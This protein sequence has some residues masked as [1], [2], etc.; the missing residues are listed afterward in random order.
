MR[1]DVL[2][3]ERLRL[4]PWTA[5]HG[6]L[7]ARLA[8]MPEVMRF[9]GK[10]VTLSA[11]EAGELAT[12]FHA[13]WRSH[14]F[15]WRGAVERDGGRLVGLVAL[16]LAHDVPGLA[17]GDHEIGWWFDPATWGRG[18]ATEGARAIVDE[19]WALGA[20][21]V[22]AR[23]QPGNVASERVA[24]KLGLTFEADTTGRYGEPVR[25]LRLHAPAA[26]G[27]EARG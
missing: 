16:E 24:A 25:I 6:A 18:Y 12:R 27:D 26:R 9:I 19:A 17:P 10:G 15:G 21:S 7:L 2:E 13:H 5:E 1:M 22:V 14:G 4:E 11:A 20:P 8:A 23:I 3:T